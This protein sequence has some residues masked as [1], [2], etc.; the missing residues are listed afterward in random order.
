[1]E[2][3]EDYNV[4]IMFQ[5]YI[6]VRQ[7]RR[8]QP[9]YFSSLF[10]DLISFFVPQYPTPIFIPQPPTAFEDVKIVC[11]NEDIIKL[12]QKKY[13]ETDKK[14]NECVVCLEDFDNEDI[15]K[16]LPCRHLY[17]VK[18]IDKWLSQ[19]SNKCPVCK[20]EVSNGVPLL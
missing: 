13:I 14:F 1:M 8:I 6:D 10:S 11:K 12:P 16:E 20:N 2:E 18:C 4:A 15:I 19:N 17:H 7:Q 9:N 5:R 3:S